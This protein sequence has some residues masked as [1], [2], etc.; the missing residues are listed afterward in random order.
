MSVATPPA[1][2][3]TP[4][5]IPD[6]AIKEQGRRWI[7]GIE[8]FAVGRWNWA[9]YRHEWTPED[10]ASMEEAFGPTLSKIEPVVVTN[11]GE[12]QLVPVLDPEGKNRGFV[13]RLYRN[14]E[15]YQDQD[16]RTV[17]AGY[18]LLAD[19]LVDDD[20]YDDMAAARYRRTSAE[21]HPDYQDEDT[22]KIYPWVLTAVSIQ[23]GKFMEAVRVLRPIANTLAAQLAQHSPLNSRHAG[24][25]IFVNVFEGDTPM[26]LADP[27]PGTAPGTAADPT[28]ALNGKF[29]QMLEMMKSLCDMQKTQPVKPAVDPAVQPEME[30]EQ[31]ADKKP[32]PG[33]PPTAQPPKFEETAQF[34]EMQTQLVETRKVAEQERALRIRTERT[35][36]ARKFVEARSTESCLKIPRKETD[37]AIALLVDA[38]H[39]FKFADGKGYRQKLEALFDALPDASVMFRDQTREVSA[40][41][42]DLQEESSV[43][44]DRVALRKANARKK[45]FAEEGQGGE[46]PSANEAVADVFNGDP[47]LYER[48]RKE[49]SVKV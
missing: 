10:L 5:T 41:E 21:L 25:A 22:G 47:A 27:T 19:M 35:A 43:S 13:G 14:A 28:A 31:M 48:Y 20:L 29:D 40:D 39:E 11:H 18:R 1:P 30:D 16:G 24:R 8:V 6:Q 46:A 15:P 23:G 17:P 26:P 4:P 45:K 12:D 44:A 34:R 36:E 49:V 3:H 33:T 9:R 38:P 32:V 2:A 37:T 7:Y 42:I